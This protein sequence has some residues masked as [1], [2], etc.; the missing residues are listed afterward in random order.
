MIQRIQTIFWLLGLVAAS[1][2]FFFPFASIDTG[3]QDAV[4]MVLNGLK[5]SESEVSS[6]PV[7]ALGIIIVLIQLVIIS[8]FRKRMLQMRL[9]I[10]NILLMI[11]WIV[12]GYFYADHAASLLNG[13][14]QPEFISVMPV[15]AIILNILAWRGVRR[16]YLMLK[17]VDRIR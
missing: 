3:G 11:G 2:L 10:Y 13:Q 6:W 17:A 9:T 15:V 4:T 5:G 12:A 1:S 8:Q 7:L 16:D 14:L